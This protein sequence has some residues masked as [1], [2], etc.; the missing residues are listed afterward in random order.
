M[1]DDHGDGPFR[2]LSD[3]ERRVA[4]RTA[5]ADKG[6]FLQ[7]IV[8]IPS[9]VGDPDW[10]RLR[11]AKAKGTPVAWWTYRTADGARAF[12]V[13][14]WNPKEP[15]ERKIIRP[16]MW[17]RLPD[18]RKGWVL[19]AMPSPRLLYNLTDI[20]K[21]DS[22]PV[23]IVEGEKCVDAAAQV[24]PDCVVT[25]WSGGTNAWAETD[26]QPLAD[27]KVLLVAD[28]DEPGRRTML[29]L[30][31][32]LASMGCTV[33]HFLPNTRDDG[34]DIADAVEQQGLEGRRAR[35][36]KQAT[37][38]KRETSGAS[39]TG[40][41]ADTDGTPD[42]ADWIEKLLER[43]K[44]DRGVPFEPECLEKL[45][46]LQCNDEAEWERVRSNLRKS[47]VRVGVL[48]RALKRKGEERDRSTLRGQVL[49]WPHDEPWPS[50]VDGAALLDEIAVLIERYVYMTQ[51]QADA[52]A[53]W[54]LYSWL[55]D[56]WDIS[57]FVGI[58]S[59]TKRCG[60]S[61]LLEVIEELV[62]RPLNLSGHTTAA[63]LFRTI[64]EYRPTCLLD[65]ADTYLRDDDDLRGLINGS[66]RRSS[67]RFL[68]MIRLGDDWISACFGTFCPKV[69]AGIGSLP[70][71]IR[72]RSILIE[73]VRR[74][75]GG[76][77]MRHWG[78]RDRAET[79]VIR[80]KIARWTRD[81]VDTVYRLR[82]DVSFPPGLDD[83]ARDAWAPLLSIAE[84]A[85]G[86]WSGQTGRPWRACETI[87]ATTKNE[88]DIAE[89]LLAD[90]R[91]VFWKVGDPD[92]LPT[93]EPGAPYNEYAP[94]ILPALNEMEE[95]PWSEY[96]RGQ[97]LSPRG[98]AN[99]LRRFKIAPV[100]IRPA[101]RP[102]AKGY[103]R[104][105]FVREWERYDI[106]DPED[107]PDPSG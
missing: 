84:R 43:A 77:K 83:R 65:E 68:R 93:G 61:L 54:I 58:T 32:R 62:P 95:R 80:R 78:D 82:R 98:L 6:Q 12:H 42:N 72:D 17:C 70:D 9:G 85:G 22:R 14:R 76:P 74:P 89:M 88:T 99:Q 23:V 60:K 96:R 25:T 21:A 55:H 71:T 27:R 39:D 34:Y 46:N 1:S 28:A 86:G 51:A 11:P 50:E 57:T 79:K 38:W 37:P 94:A 45:Y 97:S 31:T 7:P 40:E 33:H 13:V 81:H 92:Q 15:G 69:I 56:R 66:Q 35:I 24:F 87:T 26:W 41:T 44:M 104:E 4:K 20:L 90:I 30:A 49:Q 52:V 18:G 2:P 10:D 103:K 47:K 100:T 75:A 64:E 36:E 73:V 105:A 67:A 101:S 59:A 48:D 8:P 106:R 5:P 53:L 19:K 91:Q 107:G 63:A 29:E 3:A 102:T 16:V